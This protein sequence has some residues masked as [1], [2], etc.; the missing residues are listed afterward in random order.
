MSESE[1]VSAKV[2]KKA[3]KQPPF[4]VFL[5]M[6]GSELP[7]D[8]TYFIIAKDRFYIH[9]DTGIVSA[10]VEVDKISFLEDIEPSVELRLPKLPPDVICRSKMFFAGV[11]K[12]HHSESA[13]VLHYSPDQQ[14]Y[15]LHCPIQ[16]VSYGGVNYDLDDRFEGY[17]L[18]GTI[19]SHCDFNAFHSGTDIGDEEHQD[20]LHI[21]LGHVN[22]ENF[23]ASGSLVVNGTRFLVALENAALG[24]RAI[25]HGGATASRWMSMETQNRYRVSLTEEEMKH[26]KKT[27]GTEI[28]GW[29][30]D[31][32]SKQGGF[33]GSTYGSTGSS[34]IVGQGWQSEQ[35]QVGE[36]D[37]E[38]VEGEWDVESVLRDHELWPETGDDDARSFK[39]E[40]D[41]DLKDLTVVDPIA[42]GNHLAGEEKTPL[43]KAADELLNVS[44][45]VKTVGEEQD[46]DKNQA[47]EDKSDPA[48]KSDANAAIKKMVEE[49]DPE[50]PSSNKEG[51]E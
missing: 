31:Q 48:I 25:S 4:P 21:T 20:G 42:P 9:K 32:V 1:K 46:D 5:A 35:A 17:K 36:V 12:K 7:A 11:F 40:E 50:I 38:E 15:Y 24:V 8:G 23:S 2:P 30:N 37:E 6:E 45:V 19:H 33:G 14:Q 39:E 47:G 26:V 27:W 49:K 29:I 51:G 28:V 10:V 34:Y 13:L 43:D 41:A 18:V 16:V 44:K 3:V 22:N